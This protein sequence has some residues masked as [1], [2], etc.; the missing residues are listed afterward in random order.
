ML[1]PD[2]AV[3]PVV[4]GLTTPTSMAFIG[5]NDILVLEKNTGKVQRVVNGAIQGT[6]LDLTV[7]FFSERGLLGIAL[8]PGFPANPGVYLYWSQTSLSDVD[9]DDG[10][11]TPLLG[12]RVDR[13]LWN[14]ST[15]RFDTNIIQLRAF[16]IDPP[17]QP[18]RGN[19]DGGVIRFG[20]DG[21]L[22]IFIGD[23]GRRGFMQNLTCG[24]TARCPGRIVNDDQFGG[25]EPDDAHLTGVILRLNDDGSTPKD[26]PFF[27]VGAGMDG[28]VGG[29][30]QKLF[31]YGVRNSFGMAFD[32]IAG[33]L[34]TQENGDDAFDE[35]NRVE[36]GMNGGWIQIIGPVSRIREFKEI[37]MTLPPSGGVPG[38]ELQQIR[39]PPRNIANTPDEALSRLFVLP[40]SHY[41]DPQFSWKF[42][43]PPAGIGFVASD[44]L[45]HE[46]TGDLLV[47]AATPLTRGGHL[48]R[49][50]LT[51][52]RRALAFDDPRLADK[53][54]D[55]RAKHVP[56]ESESLLIGADFGVGTDIQTGPNGNVFVVS[57]T[58]GAIYEI[59][60][61]P[62]AQRTAR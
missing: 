22:Y 36:P 21:K 58:R 56:I 38:A 52:D 42:A 47:G 44:A 39:W 57:L 31:A 18:V 8:H 37:E 20:P 53:V 45:G 48:Y 12:N 41:S 34:W 28:E 32:P 50:K 59:F 10:L 15:L 6:V 33:D 27:R 55:N 60:R 16:Q 23:L 5:P 11:D 43:V 46:F 25:P 40:G 35:I 29:N 4:T 13:Y 19:H 17:R 3:R 61:K 54:D 49:F 30:I 62:E 24:P 9:T 14:G 51:D 26:N 2:L 7:N 1:H